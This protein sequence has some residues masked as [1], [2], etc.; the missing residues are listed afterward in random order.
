MDPAN[1][2]GSFSSFKMNNPEPIDVV[3]MYDQFKGFINE[4][5]ERFL[6]PLCI[7]GTTLDRRICRQSGNFTIHGTMVWPI[8][9]PDV[10]KNEIHKI[11]I[12]NSCIEDLRNL[13][14]ILD[15]TEESIYGG[16][17]IK[18]EISFNI[19]KYMNEGFF[20]RIDKLIENYDSNK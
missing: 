7:K 8:D 1:Y 18:D 20:E 10:V 16:Q 12:P 4:G 9:Y 3:E 13:L 17:N 2:N 11:F 5:N 14:A 19:E 6:M 15:I